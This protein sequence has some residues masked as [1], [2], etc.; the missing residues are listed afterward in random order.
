MLNVMF[1]LFLAG[2][3]NVL[4]VENTYLSGLI[5]TTGWGMSFLLNIV[6]HPFILMFLVMRRPMLIPGWIVGFNLLCF[7]LQIFFYFFT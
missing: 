3:L 7:L 1:L 5:I 2:R 4:P 6:L